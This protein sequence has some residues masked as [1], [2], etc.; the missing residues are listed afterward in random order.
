MP[1]TPAATE[2]TTRR[3]GLLVALLAVAAVVGGL[4]LR[5]AHLSDAPLH[6]DEAATGARVLADRLE[7]KPYRFDPRHHHGPLLTAVTVPLA[8]LRGETQWDDLTKTTLRSVPATAGVLTLLLILATA[9]TLGR[10]AVFAAV[11][12][13]T[14]PLLVVYSRV[15]IHE[16]IQALAAALLI[17]TVLR[18]AAQ[19]TGRSGRPRRTW[20]W[21]VTAGAAA[22]LML[23]NKETAVITAAA[24]TAAGLA[25]ALGHAV[26]HRLG[27]ADLQRAARTHRTNAG[28]AIA[29]AAGVAV[30]F[31]AD[32]G[33]HPAGV[34]DFFRTFFVY[35]THPE[36]HKPLTYYAW[37]MAW[38]KFR[39]GF[40]WTEAALWV[41][42]AY[43]LIASFRDPRG[44]A[45]RF[46]GLAALAEA[47]A[48][49]LIAYKT[50]WLGMVVWIQVCLVAGYGAAPM[51]ARRHPAARGAV[52]VALIAA[53][54]WQAQQSIRAAHRFPADDRNP[55]VY[56]PTA[57]AIE[58][59]A[60]WLNTLGQS[61]EA[62]DAAPLA[63]VGTHIWPL[64]WYL[65]HQ[66]PVGYWTE[67]PE[68][69]AQL[70]RVLVVPDAQHT[71]DSPGPLDT[72]HTAVPRGL[73]TDTPVWVY[74]RNDLWSHYLTTEGT[75]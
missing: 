68:G 19:G 58:T 30:L 36:H 40:W 57:P 16:P 41:P 48:Y 59:L 4:W 7:D 28:L 25:L 47:L 53:V 32:F 39:G 13:A 52:A 46:L 45:I 64:P 62:F 21:A 60:P 17:V 12:A 18:Y 3:T 15:Y 70:P 22:G 71:A 42:A 65:R 67:Y 1:P 14:S 61:S 8:Q 51:L 20:P 6:A 29:S 43:G 5:T 2:P 69:V 66:G 74:I 35:E 33:R 63:V 54:A 11:F 38:P 27:Q 31:Y 72:T 55:Y 50:P 49:S 9:P 75:P 26:V 37:L 24:W 44:G 73:R 10:G 34:L 56:V 23:S